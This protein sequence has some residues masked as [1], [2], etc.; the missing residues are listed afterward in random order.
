MASHHSHAL[1]LV[2]IVAVAA[3]F[4]QVAPSDTGMQWADP[5]N[6][7]DQ[8][9]DPS[10]GMP[11]DMAPSD[12]ND[13]GAITHE[14][15]LFGR[16]PTERCI[17]RCQDQFTPY[18]RRNCE[19]EAI[20]DEHDP[21]TYVPQCKREDQAAADEDARK[22]KEHDAGCRDRCIKT[23]FDGASTAKPKALDARCVETKPGSGWSVFKQDGYKPKDCSENKHCFAVYHTCRLGDPTKGYVDEEV[24]SGYPTCTA[25]MPTTPVSGGVWK[26]LGNSDCV[27]GKSCYAFKEAC[28]GATFERDIP[29]NERARFT[30]EMSCLSLAAVQQNIEQ[31]GS[32][33]PLQD[34]FEKKTRI[35]CDANRRDNRDGLH[36]VFG[37]YA[38]KKAR[39]ECVVE[40]PENAVVCSEEKTV[41]CLSTAPSGGE[42]ISGAHCPDDAKCYLVDKGRECSQE[43]IDPEME[44]YRP[45]S[46]QSDTPES[47]ALLD[48]LPLAVEITDAECPTGK[49]CVGLKKKPCRCGPALT[50]MELAMSLGRTPSAELTQR[51][52]NEGLVGMQNCGVSGQANCATSEAN[53]I[54]AVSIPGVS[55]RVLNTVP[56]AEVQCPAQNNC[57][58]TGN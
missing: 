8:N 30:G 15:P 16:N 1:S 54:S 48:R 37:C 39:C 33:K 4:L 45:I 58:V 12:D 10:T 27:T 50:E 9:I 53:A 28:T 18:V 5:S 22:W 52:A 2:A 56:F 35:H 20:E 24:Y 49:M 31:Y 14:D 3:V 44:T 42:H 47:R 11:D 46:C 29:E 40:Q 57:Y 17:M 13:G 19:R 36:A 32:I 41:K 21:S 55:M 34:F 26:G 38:K 51:A 25:T 43:G 23:C 7:P 6:M